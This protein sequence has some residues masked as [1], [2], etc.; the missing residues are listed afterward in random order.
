MAC[1]V[2]HPQEYV[3][4]LNRPGRYQHVDKILSRPSAFE[5][6]FVPGNQVSSSIVEAMLLSM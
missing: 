6:D 5:E 3:A 1:N 4:D 2:L